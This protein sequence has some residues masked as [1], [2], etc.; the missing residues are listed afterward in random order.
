MELYLSRIM[1]NPGSK[2]VMHDLGSP[3]ELHKSICRCFPAIEDQGNRPAHEKETPR[4]AYKLLHRLDNK[5]D[6]IVLYVQSTVEPEWHRLSPGYA[7]RADAKP[8][9]RL[10]SAISN[11]DR[12]QFRLAANPTKRA[13]K[14]DD[15]N[16]KFKD[17]KKRRRIDIRTEDGRI[18]WL[19]RKGEECGFR[20]CRVTSTDGTASVET[21]IGRSLT[22]KHEKGR[23]T[24]GSAVFEGVL[25]VT[26]ADAFRNTITNGIG[27]GKA[28]GFGLMSVA[29]A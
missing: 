9:H 1:L 25:E 11:G 27:P 5:G 12:L 4:N 23:V 17:E 16:T 6:S 24:L 13:G 28:Y 2:A 26:D 18:K 3:R 8:I 15:G 22:F 14:N 20:L 19:A 10:Y 7:T 29:R 21:S